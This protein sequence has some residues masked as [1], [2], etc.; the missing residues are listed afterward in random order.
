MF[1]ETKTNNSNVLTVSEGSLV[2][3]DDL[4]EVL[5]KYKGTNITVCGFDKFALLYDKEKDYILLDNVD[6]F[7]ENED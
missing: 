5:N 4:I 7:M 3:V 1:K 6:Y 2:S